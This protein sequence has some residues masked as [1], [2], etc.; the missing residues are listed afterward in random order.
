MIIGSLKKGARMV[1]PEKKF[2]V[3]HVS[4]GKDVVNSTLKD[5]VLNQ[6]HTKTFRRVGDD[7]KSGIDIGDCQEYI[8]TEKKSIRV[9]VEI[10]LPGKPSLLIRMILRKTK[11]GWH[12]LVSRGSELSCFLEIIRP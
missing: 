11:A 10:S 4:R 12:C 1:F 6:I 5:E 3:L 8:P 7:I 2:L 9:G